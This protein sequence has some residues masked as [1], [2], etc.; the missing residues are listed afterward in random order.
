MNLEIRREVPFKI[1]FIGF[2][3]TIS[4]V[5]EHGCENTMYVSHVSS[6]SLRKSKHY[7]GIRSMYIVYSMG[8]D[9]IDVPGELGKRVS[10]VGRECGGACP[11]KCRQSKSYCSR[12]I[13]AVNFLVRL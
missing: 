8:L 9:H 6:N 7:S 12:K 1:H 2:Q 4:I 3:V 13:F 11:T 5:V 10:Q